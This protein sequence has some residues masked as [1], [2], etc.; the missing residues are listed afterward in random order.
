MTGGWTD[1]PI[2]YIKC[3]GNI[4]TEHV[5]IESV[6]AMIT[7]SRL[8]AVA[9]HDAD[10]DCLMSISRWCRWRTQVYAAPLARHREQFPLM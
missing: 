2:I 9:S 5:S 4:I 6:M 8:V 1:G 7:S 3:N 10:D